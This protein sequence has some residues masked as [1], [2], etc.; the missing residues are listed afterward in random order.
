MIHLGKSNWQDV[1]EGTRVRLV[2]EEPDGTVMRFDANGRGGVPK[3]LLRVMSRALG[4]YRPELEAD[5]ERV[6]TF[7]ELGN[8]ISN[9]FTKAFNTAWKVPPPAREVAVTFGDFV[10][11]DDG[12]IEV[13]VLVDGQPAGTQEIRLRDGQG[14]NLIER[15]KVKEY[16]Y[17]DGDVLVLGPG[18]FTDATDQGVISYNGGNYRF[19]S[20]SVKET[21]RN[22]RAYGWEVGRGRV[23][24]EMIEYDPENPF[25]F[26]DWREQFGLPQVD[27][28]R[29]PKLTGEYVRLML[30]GSARVVV[31]VNGIGHE[32]TE[33]DVRIES[34]HRVTNAEKLQ[35]AELR[36]DEACTAI[37][38]LIETLGPE[39]LDPSQRWYSVMEQYAPDALQ[40]AIAQ[41]ATDNIGPIKDISAALTAFVNHYGLDSRLNLA[42]HRVAE[43]LLQH[44]ETM[45]EVN[46]EIAPHGPYVSTTAQGGRCTASYEVSTAGE[47]RTA[48]CS[49]P[50]GHVDNGLLRL[51]THMDSQGVIWQTSENWEEILTVATPY[52]APE[53]THPAGLVNGQCPSC[54]PVEL[55]NSADPFSPAPKPAFTAEDERE[56]HDR[57]KGGIDAAGNFYEEDQPVADVEAAFDAGEKSTTEAPTLDVDLQPNGK[58]PR[59]PRY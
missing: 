35:L 3:Y 33:T 15:A 51:R 34:G 46:H 37:R 45:A 31:L 48:Y 32:Y 1:A 36:L 30:D 55:D 59:R 53:C 11:H 17:E 40:A 29:D 5:A 42:D 8:S 14:L 24:Q 38:E 27:W 52:E 28:R 54:G 26:S 57:R 50:A 39:I 19:D 41:A 56:A 58:R 22:A 44:I 10:V 25:L 16:P 18:V 49:R 4:A 20:A 12:R 9:I 43:I 47:S 23:M 7:V 6:N 13:S 21:D 2:V